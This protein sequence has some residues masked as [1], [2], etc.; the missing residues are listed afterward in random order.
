LAD[1]PL[2]VGAVIAAVPCRDGESFLRSLFEPLDYE[3]S[4]DGPYYKVILRGRVRSTG[5]LTHVYVFVPVL[6]ADKHYW[7]GND[8]VEKL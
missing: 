1:Q 7:V 4:V 2:H 5:S 3:V 6:D 8:E